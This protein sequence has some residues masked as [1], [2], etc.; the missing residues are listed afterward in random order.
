M[1]GFDPLRSITAI[2]L[3]TL[4]LEVEEE[5]RH[6]TCRKKANGT[7]KDDSHGYSALKEF[8]GRACTLATGS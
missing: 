6:S 5:A 2:R 3:E 7:R 4:A 1:F 8:D